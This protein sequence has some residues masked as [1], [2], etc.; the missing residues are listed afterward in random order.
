VSG[1]EPVATSSLSAAIP[2]PNSTADD[3][4]N[5]CAEL[6]A[7]VARKEFGVRLRDGAEV[8]SHVWIRWRA[9]SRKSKNA[10]RLKHARAYKGVPRRH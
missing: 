8:C 5:V 2:K 6:R 10:E 7:N 1:P 9:M 3:S 4:S